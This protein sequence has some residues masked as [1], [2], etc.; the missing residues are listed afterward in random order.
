MKPPLWRVISASVLP[1]AKPVDSF[2]RR[3]LRRFATTK[4]QEAD[5]SLQECYSL[6][7]ILANHLVIGFNRIARGGMGDVF[8]AEHRGMERTVAIKVIIADS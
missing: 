4:E 5:P 3:H 6:E 7:A 8:L 1:A 2:R